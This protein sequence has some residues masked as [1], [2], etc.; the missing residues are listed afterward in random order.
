MRWKIA[1][2]TF[3]LSTSQLV[4]RVIGF[5]Y[6][7]FLARR[8]GVENF[9]IY[10]F[11]LAFVYNFFPIADFGLE[12]LVLKDV[13]RNLAKAQFYFARLLP[14]RLILGIL[15]YLGIL[16]TAV[17][18]GQPWQEIQ[19]LAIFGLGLIPYNLINLIIALQNAREKM[20]YMAVTGVALNA[21]AIAFGSFFVLLNFSLNWILLA[22]FLAHLLVLLWFLGRLGKLG[23]EVKFEIDW[24][25][26]RQAL[27]QSWVFAALTIIAVF[28]LRTSIIFVGLLEGDYQVGIYGSAFKFIEA[29]ILLPQSLA[30]ALFPLSSRL[31]EKSKERLRKIYLNGL[32]VL[33]GLG[34]L[35]GLGMVGGAKF[36][37]PLVYGEKYLAAVPVFSIL[38]VAMFFFFLNS[39][40]GN[41]GQNSP[42]VKTFLFLLVGKFIFHAFL[43]LFLISR[44]SILGAAWAVAISEMLGTI[45]NNWFVLRIL[46]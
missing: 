1:Q 33:G 41:I 46:R 2:N 35:G 9:G 13:S 38:G 32:G 19:Y 40:S 25:F 42:K 22:Y 11:T 18:L 10:N 36:I 20:E 8:L 3:F 29:G 5:F 43:C 12:R 44:W 30:L 15:G 27:S 26:W 28:Y 14:L 39:L 6:F 17:I 7:I 24:Q 4:A 45:I 37:I 23:L 31:F 16:G 34:I 21:L